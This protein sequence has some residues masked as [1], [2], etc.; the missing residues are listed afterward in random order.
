[1]LAIGVPIIAFAI[2]AVTFTNVVIRNLRVTVVDADRSATSLIYIQAV[3]SAPGVSLA[4][5]SGDMTSAMHAIRSGQAIA[6]V[7][8]PENFERDLIARKRPQIVILY[9]QQYFTP[10]YSASA[11]LSNAIAAA[12]AT[13]PTTS[14][15]ETTYVPGSFV[16]EEYVLTNPRSTMRSSCSEQFCR[17]CS[18]S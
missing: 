16:A 5:R 8:I 10:G 15:V 3:A 12:T 11:A 18:T 13:L 6:A 7:Y 17:P 4:D 14:P 2:L 9:N 1:M